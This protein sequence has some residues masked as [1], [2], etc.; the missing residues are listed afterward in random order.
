MLTG[1]AF[2]GAIWIGE[3][4]I[5]TTAAIYLRVELGVADTA[6]QTCFEC[7]A[8]LAC[9]CTCIARKGISVFYESVGKL[10]GRRYHLEDKERRQQRHDLE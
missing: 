4:F 6:S 2:L 3:S 8:A 9:T 1:L 10:T 5:S 7:C